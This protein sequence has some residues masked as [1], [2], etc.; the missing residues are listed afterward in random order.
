MVRDKFGLMG[1]SDEKAYYEQYVT[2]PKRT[3]LYQAFIS[4]D[5]SACVVGVGLLY[6]VVVRRVF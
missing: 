4:D 5:I 6:S 3:Y 2:T 1:A